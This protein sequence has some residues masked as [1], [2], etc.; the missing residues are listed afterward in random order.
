MSISLTSLNK[1][2]RFHTPGRPDLRQGV[3]AYYG[4]TTITLS[5]AQII[6]LT[7]NEICA[8]RG[9]GIVY[10]HP[11][12]TNNVG[13]RDRHVKMTRFDIEI[14]DQS[15]STYALHR[16]T[17]DQRRKIRLLDHDSEGPAQIL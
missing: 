4:G 6:A 16:Q 3:R 8:L 14:P 1:S 2:F 15:H 9:Q 10:W 12:S 7:L 17:V 13:D 11:S 5:D